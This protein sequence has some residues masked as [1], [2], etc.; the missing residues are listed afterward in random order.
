[1]NTQ[2][3]MNAQ[4]NEMIERLSNEFASHLKKMSSKQLESISRGDVC[5]TM[6]PAVKSEGGGAKNSK[7]WKE[8]EMNHF[9]F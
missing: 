1:M 8:Q 9:N 5:F 3:N 4:Y 7:A 6:S 2:Q